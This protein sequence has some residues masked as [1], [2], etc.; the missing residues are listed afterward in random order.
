MD[1][2]MGEIANQIAIVLGVLVACFTGP[3]A[4]VSTI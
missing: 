3:A 2:S 4:D 1:S